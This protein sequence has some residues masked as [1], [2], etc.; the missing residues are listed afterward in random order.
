MEEDKENITKNLM[1]YRPILR[2]S[3]DMIILKSLQNFPC[4]LN[5]IQKMMWRIY[6]EFIFDFSSCKNL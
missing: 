3:T 5:L 4:P 2:S 6:I 1:S